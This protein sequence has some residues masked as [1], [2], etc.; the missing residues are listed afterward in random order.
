M[1]SLESDILP[2]QAFSAK[3]V[4]R[5]FMRLY[6]PATPRLKMTGSVQA[7]NERPVKRKA[8]VPASLS[9][10]KSD[11]SSA[12]AP[13]LKTSKK[14]RQSSTSQLHSRKLDK[15]AAGDCHA[16]IETISRLAVKCRSKRG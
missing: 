3:R 5:T 10:T 14:N 6:R 2:T 12:S 16:H 13:R 11:R 9:E 15:P 1:W 7:K 8:L 4:S